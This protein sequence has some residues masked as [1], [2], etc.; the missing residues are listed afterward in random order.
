MSAVE[1]YRKKIEQNPYNVSIVVEEKFTRGEITTL[2]RSVRWEREW[3][4]FRRTIEKLPGLL[5]DNI[6]GRGVVIAKILQ[7]VKYTTGMFKNVAIA[8]AHAAQAVL[9]LVDIGVP[10]DKAISIVAEATGLS[11][12]LIERALGGG[13][14]GG[15]APQASV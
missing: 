6:V 8:S 3:E 1:V 11:K 13:G 4:P 9:A 2:P 10:Q 14:G 15:R 12:G 7:S 5:P